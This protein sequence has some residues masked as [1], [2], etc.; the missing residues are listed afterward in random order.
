M[1]TK[2]NGSKRKATGAPDDSVSKKNKV[3]ERKEEE[4]VTSPPPPNTACLLRFADTE[5]LLTLMQI[6]NG[7]LD[8][9][10]IC[11]INDNEMC[12]LTPKAEMLL[13]NT[14]MESK[15]QGIY[16]KCLDKSHTCM[17][18]AKL[19]CP[20]VFVDPDVA[21]RK[22]NHICVNVAMLS[23]HLKSID[24]G[25]NVQLQTRINDPQLYIR[26]SSILNATHHH[27]SKLATT[28]GDNPDFDLSS[29]T[30]EYTLVFNLRTFQKIINMAKHIESDHVRIQLFTDKRVTGK[31]KCSYLVMQA[32]GVTSKIENV[33]G[34]KTITEGNITTIVIQSP[35]MGIVDDDDNNPANI[36]F[37]ALHRDFTGLFPVTYLHTF[38]RGLEEPQLLIRLAANPNKPMV[39]TSKLGG[40]D[41]SFIAY[42]LAAGT[43]EDFPLTVDSFL[44]E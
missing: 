13:T 32:Y 39:L 12:D 25:Y 30:F 15:F 41:R 22:D 11:I 2:E 29:M 40:D 8:D 17:V 33:F 1:A 42:V 19:Y 34:S 27:L 18:F 7:I 10:P 21:E 38:L 5:Q 20:D 14:I 26:S 24:A 6:L 16:A 9:A 31:T 43:S 3:V 36:P 4:E 37:S 44:N 23:A 28:V 35:D